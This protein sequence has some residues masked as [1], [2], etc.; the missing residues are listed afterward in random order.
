MSQ[1]TLSDQ[2]WQ[3]IYLRLR[4]CRGIYVR[5]ETSTRRFVEAV[6]WILR[7]GAPWR[8]LPETYG[9]WNTVYKRFADWSEKGI[10]TQVLQLC[11]QTPD[12]EWIIP[13]STT[14]R[15]HPCA[16]GAPKKK[17]AKPRKPWGGAEAASAPR[18]TS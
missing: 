1:V 15:A 9:P 16:A 7:S 10:W 17:V 8:L 6:L 11:A 14:I 13:D 18:S 3:V 2:E 4:D 5:N 12:R